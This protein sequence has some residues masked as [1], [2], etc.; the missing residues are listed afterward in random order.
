VVPEEEVIE[1]VVERHEG[2]A[3]HHLEETTEAEIETIE[4]I[5]EI[6][7]TE[8]TEEE[9]EMIEIQGEVTI[10]MTIPERGE[11]REVTPGRRLPETQAKGRTGS[12]RTTEIE[13]R[14]EASQMLSPSREIASTSENTG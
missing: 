14:A 2:P 5:E 8:L 3:D 12:I 13:V 11:T 4:A 7:E 1:V 10:E 6:E 9:I